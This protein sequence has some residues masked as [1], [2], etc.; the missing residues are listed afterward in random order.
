MAI[1]PSARAPEARLP[2][3][4][5]SA[6]PGGAIASLWLKTW[7]RDGVT[8]GRATLGPTVWAAA[9]SRPRIGALA[10][11]A[12]IVA[13]CPPTGPIH[14][15][16]DLRIQLL[17]APP[18]GGWAHLVCHPLKVGRRLFVG[19]VLV[20]AGHAP[21]A[22]AIVTFLNQPVPAPRP[23]DQRAPGR[24]AVVGSPL[25]GSSGTAALESLSSFESHI[26]PSI[27]DDRTLVVEPNASIANP[28]TRTIQGGV[29]AT[30]G[31][32]ASEHVLAPHGTFGVIDLDIRYL[33]RLS[34]G[35]LVARADLLQRTDDLGFVRVTLC[36]RGEGDRVVSVVSTVCR[37]LGSAENGPVA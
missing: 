1:S 26:R 7:V 32:L 25:P 31:E 14:P 35:P 10:T 15:T 3:H 21:F 33:G 20:D 8:H 9:T 18:A 22:R 27:A 11:M 30:I 17:A 5:P 13:G 19:E 23:Q 29:Q 34:A 6:Q 28:W 2:A 24:M 4:D 37:R 12:D 16:V 36:D